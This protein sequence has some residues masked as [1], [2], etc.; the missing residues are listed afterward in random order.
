[1]RADE[2]SPLTFEDRKMRTELK[3]YKDFT[4]KKNF[5]Y[6]ISLEVQ[7]FRVTWDRGKDAPGRRGS[8]LQ[9]I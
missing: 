8:Q 5:Q 3:G 6:Q 4:Y 7:H 1:M 2:C 9:G